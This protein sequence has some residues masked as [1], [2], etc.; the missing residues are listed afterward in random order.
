[1]VQVSALLMLFFSTLRILMVRVSRSLSP[2]RAPLLLQPADRLPGGG[3]L[4]G[5]DDD[6]FREWYATLSDRSA[7]PAHH[8]ST[9]S[10]DSDRAHCL[11][12]HS[13]THH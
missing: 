7:V 11:P 10:P 6:G 3:H 8:R 12:G 9:G 1:M 13:V 2:A 5:Q 4:F